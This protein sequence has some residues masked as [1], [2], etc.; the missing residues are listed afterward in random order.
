LVNVV[1]FF[2]LERR[3]PETPTLERLAVLAEAHPLV[4]EVG[5]DLA[6]AFEFL[7]LLRIRHQHERIAMG[8]E[9][10]NYIQPDRLSTLDRQSL[11]Q[12]CRVLLRVIDRI[13]RRYA[14]HPPG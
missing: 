9:P 5:E 12:I 7:S 11:R 1:R 2:S 10:D 14:E 3:I 13:Q 6:H 8:L 4:T